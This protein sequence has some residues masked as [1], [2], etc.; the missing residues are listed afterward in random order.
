MQLNNTAIQ[1]LL[2]INWFKGI[3]IQ[4]DS[5]E[6]TTNIKLISQNSQNIDIELYDNVLVFLI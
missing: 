4:N 6:A 5:E 1:L 3:I 2:N